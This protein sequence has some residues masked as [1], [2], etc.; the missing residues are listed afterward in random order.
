MVAESKL[1]GELFIGVLVRMAL[2]GWRD[3]SGEEHCLF[4]QRF[5]VQIPATT[6]WFTIIC[7]GI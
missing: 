4:F 5:R 7:N 1:G 2:K 6:G 3:V